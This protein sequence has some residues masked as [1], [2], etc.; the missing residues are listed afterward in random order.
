MTLE[1]TLPEQ[2]WENELAR[3][4]LQLYRADV[5]RTGEEA[6]ATSPGVDAGTTLGSDSMAGGDSRSLPKLVPSGLAQST[7]QLDTTIISRPGTSVN[8]SA[9]LGRTP[10][11]TGTGART[12]Q[13]DGGKKKVMRLGLRSGADDYPGMG[14]EQAL[15]VVDWLAHRLTHSCGACA[16]EVAKTMINI[17][18][19]GGGC[20]GF[21]RRRVGPFPI[22]FGG[23]GGSVSAQAVWC[24]LTALQP[25]ARP[26]SAAAVRAA[27][28]SGTCPHTLCAEL[29]A[30]ESNGKYAKYVRIVEKVLVVPVRDP[31]KPD[32][33]SRQWRQLVVVANMFAAKY[34]EESKFGKALDML[35]KGN[36]LADEDVAVRAAPMNQRYHQLLTLDPRPHPHIP[37][38]C[39]PRHNASCERSC[40]TRMAF[41]TF[42]EA[43]M[44]R[45][46]RRCARRCEYTLHWGS[47]TMWPRCTCTLQSSCRA[48]GTTPKLCA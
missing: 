13:G 37:H 31:Q 10:A 14:Y 42:G 15:V 38:R 18:G 17:A 26:P 12:T 28:A 25:G 4:I 32:V 47:W 45:L 20:K 46:W 16:E 40:R 43:S 30:L 11:V 3:Q 39:Q 7:I 33:V 29:A 34:V 48:C 23:G 24:G 9:M 44:Q 6:Q 36:A 35:R 41:T 1:A 19:G 5:V 22:W 21:V 2:Q 27:D 8:D